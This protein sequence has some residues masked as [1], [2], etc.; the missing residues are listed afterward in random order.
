MPLFGTTTSRG[1][2]QCFCKHREERT[3]E[4]VVEQRNCKRQCEMISREMI[5]WYGGIFFWHFRQS[6]N[7]AWTWCKRAMLYRASLFLS[8]L[9]RIA[10]SCLH[11]GTNCRMQLC[12]TFTLAL[13]LYWL[14]V[15]NAQCP[16][17]SSPRRFSANNFVINDSRAWITRVGEIT[18]V[19]NRLNYI[20]EWSRGIEAEDC[21]PSLIPPLSSDENRNPSRIIGWNFSREVSFKDGLVILHDRK[22]MA[23]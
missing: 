19:R 13:V 20:V 16:Y 23:N 10:F 5:F 22:N 17:S 11:F 6:V 9:S 7:L 21:V 8:F 1:N 2:T 12:S 15:S 18:L 4:S 3:L 14:R